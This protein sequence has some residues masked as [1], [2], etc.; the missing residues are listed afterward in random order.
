MDQ[1]LDPCL[2]TLTFSAVNAAAAP[3]LERAGQFLLG[4]NKL[5]PTLVGGLLGNR[6]DYLISGPAKD[7]LLQLRTTEP[8]LNHDMERA[9][10]RAVLFATAEMVRQAEIR[11]AAERMTVLGALT[12]LRISGAAYVV[13]KMGRGVAADLND[14]EKTLP[15]PLP[16]VAIFLLD[17]NVDIAVRRER[18]RGVLRSNLDADILRWVGAAGM[19][20]VIESLLQTGWTIDTEHAKNVSR[21]WFDLVGLGFVELLKTDTRLSTV[22]Q[23]KLLA[24]IAAKEPAVAP[25]ASFDEFKGSLDRLFAPLERIEDSLKILH[26]K[27][28]N[29]QQD[30]RE[31]KSLVEQLVSQRAVDIVRERSLASARENEILSRLTEREAELR[32][33]RDD[34]SLSQKK[35]V[36]VLEQLSQVLAEKA[37]LVEK[38]AQRDRSFEVELAEFRS[39]MTSLAESKD[40]RIR[41]ALERFAAG[42]RVGAF[43][44]IADIVQAENR[45]AAR[46]LGVRQAFRVREVAALAM[47]MKDR[48]EKSTV[49]V[50][51]LWEEAQGLDDQYH[52]GW[53]ELTR[54]YMDLGN[55]DEA[56]G[57]A[58]R[59]LAHSSDARSRSVGL[60]ELGDVLVA[61]GELVEARK[62][63]EEG[64]EIAKKLALGNPGSAAA[65]RDIVV[66]CWKLGDLT[67]EKGYWQRALEIFER[68]YSEG[69]LA[70]VDEKFLPIL[71]ERA[72]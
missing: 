25:I 4:D 71:R 59:A 72:K 2:L 17:P 41:G 46:A 24:E 30:V 63:Y 16:D 11:L 29:I 19:P 26:R 58:E 52:W 33:V 44:V 47:M 3:L 1:L 27:L 35:H 42:D 14:V 20:D 57:A 10:R 7:F 5:V 38:I 6:F 15:A 67:G 12:P 54:L 69:R 23:S 8:A 51:A 62:R 49:E 9:S 32:L 18:M 48:G 43:P 61:G 50:A 36:A 56:R 55:L 39:A 65:Q 31:V 45:A 34:L 37:E 28:E 53:V 70:P 22:F 64:L 13:D 21:N 40:P 60:D 66:S 68:L